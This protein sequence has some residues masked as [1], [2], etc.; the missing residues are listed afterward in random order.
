MPLNLFLLPM[1]NPIL[2]PQLN[3]AYKNLGDTYLKFQVDQQTPAILAIEYAQEVLVVPAGRITP[4]PNMP[5]CVLG[6]LNQG[7]RVLW[8]IDLAQMLNLQPLNTNAKQYHMAIIR[9]G[10]VPLG[11][12]VQEVKGVT[13]FTSDCIQSSQGIIPPVL[14]PYLH[15]YILQHQEIVLALKAESIVNSPMLHAE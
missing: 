11:L 12:V 6:L 13:R 14:M 9:V 3:Q 10:Q 5:N 1:N 7:N 8:I 4:M 2:A 15:G